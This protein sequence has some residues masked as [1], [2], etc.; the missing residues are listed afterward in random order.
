MAKG[1]WAI[2]HPVQKRGRPLISGWHGHRPPQ[3]GAG[4]CDI[5]AG[6]SCHNDDARQGKE[7]QEKR[8]QKEIGFPDLL[9]G[10]LE[11]PIKFMY[12]NDTL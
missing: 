7:K 9:A 11:T 1:K 6:G 4:H 10:W 8:I 5:A 12:S 3:E 2:A